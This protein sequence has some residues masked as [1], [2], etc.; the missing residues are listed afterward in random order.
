MKSSL[1]A[2]ERVVHGEEFGLIQKIMLIIDVLLVTY[3]CLVLAHERA[4]RVLHQINDGHHGLMTC[5]H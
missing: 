1:V 2:Y 5:K 4:E 3:D